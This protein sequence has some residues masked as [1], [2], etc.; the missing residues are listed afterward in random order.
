LFQRNIQLLI[1]KKEQNTRSYMLV[2][3]IIIITINEISASS[4]QLQFFFL[5]CN[6]NKWNW[7]LVTCGVFK[8]LTFEEIHFTMKN[9]GWGC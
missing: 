7:A 6:N 9:E 1:E 8:A 3:T 4:D 2:P 5:L